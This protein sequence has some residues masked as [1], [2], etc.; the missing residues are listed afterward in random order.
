[1]THDPYQSYPTFGAFSGLT[2]PFSSPYTAMQASAIN[3]A[4]VY[5]PLAMNAGLPWGVPATAVQQPYGGISPQQLQLALAAQSAWQNPFIGGA[6]QHPLTAASLQN[7]FA[8]AGLQN[9]FTTASQQN[10]F[11]TA[12]LQNPFATTG[13]QNPF[14]TASLQN[15][16]ATAGLQNPF[17]TVGLQN[18]YATAGLQNPLLNPVLGQMAAQIYQQPYQQQPYQQQPYQQP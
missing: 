12:G 13:L 18:P 6:I 2:N 3:P 4:A 11:V 5:N 1:M 15:P 17:A 10:P 8:I 7:P 14:A 16:F 9:P